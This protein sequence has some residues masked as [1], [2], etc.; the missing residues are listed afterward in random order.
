MRKGQREKQ[1][2]GGKAAAVFAT[3]AWRNIIQIFTS[4]PPLSLPTVFCFSQKKIVSFLLLPWDKRLLKGQSK[5]FCLTESTQKSGRLSKVEIT[6]FSL[7]L[8]TP[9]RNSQLCLTHSLC[10]QPFAVQEQARPA[11]RLGHWLLWLHQVNTPPRTQ[12]PSWT[13]VLCTRFPSTPTR[14]C[15]TE[16]PGIKGTLPMLTGPFLQ[17][18]L[19]CSLLQEQVSSTFLP[20]TDITRWGRLSPGWFQSSF[21]SSLLSQPSPRLMKPLI[22]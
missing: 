15:F 2:A 3:S 11:C 7:K 16:S 20:S 8:L 12:W 4:S 19:S 10:L 18:S 13:M 6:L 21:V 14:L 17:K 22:N 5:H 1:R 9:S